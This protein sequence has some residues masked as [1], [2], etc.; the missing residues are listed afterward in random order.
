MG[1]FRMS[2]V[3]S[4]RDWKAASGTQWKYKIFQLGFGCRKILK[5]TIFV[6]ESSDRVAS[7]NLAPKAQLQPQGGLLKMK[8]TCAFRLD[9]SG[10]QSCLF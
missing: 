2:P 6:V 5:R 3:P 9:L 1:S 7:P 10:R 4:V 8:T